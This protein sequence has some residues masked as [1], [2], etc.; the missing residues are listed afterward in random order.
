MPAKT[1]ITRLQHVTIARRATVKCLAPFCSVSPAVAQCAFSIRNSILPT[2]L[3]VLLKP[4]CWRLG[5]RFRILSASLQ[6]PSGLPVSQTRHRTLGSPAKSSGPFLGPKTR[7]KNGAFQTGPPQLQLHLVRLYAAGF[8]LTVESDCVFKTS[9]NWVL[10][11]SSC[12]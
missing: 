1:I 4:D 7:S 10:H 5:E 9:S 6:A 3:V 12:L 2:L 8:N 11:L